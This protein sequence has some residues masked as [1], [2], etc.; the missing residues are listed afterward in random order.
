ML[1]ERSAPG[2][3][4][5]LSDVCRDWE[6]ATQAAAEVGVR[7]VL[8]RFGVILSGKG[9]AL[10]KMLFPFRLGLGG[11]LGSGRQFM[12]WIALDD[13]VH[14]TLH[15]LDSSAI[16]GPVDFVAPQ[17]VTNLEYTRTLGR[18]LGRPT[19]FAVPAPFARLA[20]GQ[21][22]DE[23]LLSSQ[24]IVPTRLTASGYTFRH[25]T[26]DGTA[27]CSSLNERR[28][29]NAGHDRCLKYLATKRRNPRGFD[30][31]ILRRLLLRR[32]PRDPRRCFPC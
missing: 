22:A 31:G 26:L 21:M 3:G 32:G 14:A 9:G 17:P 29:P 25:P 10:Q 13:V 16:T 24:R 6:A 15:C 20:F 7:V 1:D 28:S 23:L 19:F 11:K 4:D 12:S 5:F 2:S 18:V 30:R 27:E 8:E